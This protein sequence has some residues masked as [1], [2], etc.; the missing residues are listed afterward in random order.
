MG[1]FLVT[2]ALVGSGAAMVWL[3]WLGSQGRLR[4]GST[5]R[6]AHEAAAGPIGVTGGV[7]VLAGV[8]VGVSGLDSQPGQI[9]LAVG[10]LALVAGSLTTAVVV[11]RARGGGADEA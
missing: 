9:A 2:V 10:T 3:A 8:A 4:A 7:L 6:A 5:R 11:R 1:T